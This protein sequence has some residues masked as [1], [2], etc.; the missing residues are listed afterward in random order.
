[1]HIDGPRDAA[2]NVHAINLALKP[3]EHTFHRGFYGEGGVCARGVVAYRKELA[4]DTMPW[5]ISKRKTG[6][7]MDEQY[8]GMVAPVPGATV[9]SDRPSELQ[10][11][12]QKGKQQ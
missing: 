9:I 6:I 3:D 4:H 12:Q 8:F 10:S 1:L 5:M 7:W 2:Q 11:Q